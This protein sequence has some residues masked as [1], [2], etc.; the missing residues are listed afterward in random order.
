MGDIMFVVC[1]S[2]PT[3]WVRG[4]RLCSFCGTFPGVTPG[5]R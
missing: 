2:E 1:R 5:G 3:K 4:R